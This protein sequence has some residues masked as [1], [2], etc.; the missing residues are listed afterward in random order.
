LIS[1]LA[2]RGIPLVVCGKNYRPVAVLLP[3][4][5]H[6]EQAKRFQAQTTMGKPRKKSIW[7]QVIR[8]KVLNQSLILAHWGAP[9]PVLDR[10]ARQVRS[11]D[12]SNVEAQAARYYWRAL[13]G[14]E[15]RRDVDKEGVNAQLNYGYAILRAAVARAVVSAGLHPS[16]GIF[17]RD[18]KNSFQLV[19]DLME[20][21]R[22][23]VDSC[24]RESFPETDVSPEVKRRLAAIVEL[25]C[26]M[27]GE[28]C[29]FGQALHRYVRE[30]VNAVMD[31]G[32]ALQFPKVIFSLSGVTGQC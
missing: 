11:G 10:L 22:P 9:L 20:P 30:Y 15:F 8:E 1:A 19:D 16:L 32:E 13:F 17:H 7:Q 25:E 26:G 12:P 21:F 31:T 5:Q 18:P 14:S 3:I 2:N 27:A 29:A 6:Y 28:R 4:E 24:V 23:I